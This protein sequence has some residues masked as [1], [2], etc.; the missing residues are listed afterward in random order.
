MAF[1]GFREGL[2][3]QR[4]VGVETGR[5][6]MH[7]TLAAV[8]ASWCGKTEEQARV[9]QVLSRLTQRW[10]L[11]HLSLVFSAWSMFA[12]FQHV[13]DR[14][15]CRIASSLFARCGLRRSV[16]L[17]CFAL[18]SWWLGKITSRGLVP[19]EVL[20]ASLCRLAHGWSRI[21]RVAAQFQARFLHDTLTS[22]H[23]NVLLRQYLARSYQRAVNLSSSMLCGRVMR[24]WLSLALQK[25]CLRRNAGRVSFQCLHRELSC[26]FNELRQQTLRKRSS[27]V[28]RSRCV[29]QFLREVLQG[30][31][32]LSAHD[33]RSKMIE[34]R[35]VSCWVL[36]RCAWAFDVWLWRV[37]TV[38][39]FEKKLTNQMT[40]RRLL[41]LKLKAWLQFSGHLKLQRHVHGIQKQRAK[42]R[43]FGSIVQYTSRC[44]KIQILA[45]QMREARLE[46]EKVMAW[47]AW[48]EFARG[49]QISSK[50]SSK[51]IFIE[52]DLLRSWVMWKLV[53]STRQASRKMSIRAFAKWLEGNSRV[54][55][56]QLFL[57][58][59]VEATRTRS[60]LLSLSACAQNP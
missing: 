47:L 9:R 57:D 26:V 42:A 56:L 7:R 24:T 34:S 58:F 15:R 1:E 3:R 49:C 44:Q 14:E 32:H 50:L 39:G 31:Q 27:K 29:R 51:W 37:G 19:S 18:E 13:L 60:S 8:F 36:G 45:D 17:L 4:K 10:L 5:V 23:A 11:S 53:L 55:P 59:W 20:C 46:S 21:E 48:C 35:L 33:R 2:E 22:W 40:S 54:D 25:K 41:K 16:R 43:I 30:W 12:G 52:R 38:T 28:M 6:W